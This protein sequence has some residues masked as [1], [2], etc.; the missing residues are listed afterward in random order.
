[1]TT[2]RRKKSTA[3]PT[4]KRKAEEESKM[5]NKTTPRRSTRAR[6]SSEGAQSVKTLSSKPAG[7]K[8]DIEDKGDKAF[9]DELKP[10]GWL[11]KYDPLGQYVFYYPPYNKAV[12]GVTRFT[13]CEALGRKVEEVGI[14]SILRNARKAA[15]EDEDSSDD[16]HTTSMNESDKAGLSTINNTAN[17][18]SPT[19][20]GRRLWEKLDGI[21]SKIWQTPKDA[22]NNVLLLLKQKF[23]ASQSSE[24]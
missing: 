18:L 3:T 7:G 21:E 14:K 22:F 9:C 10:E 15:G 5:L 2:S 4:R 20:L 8:S 19:Q 16:E 11:W 23:T 24:Q 17:A 13:T 12:E 6:I 1:M